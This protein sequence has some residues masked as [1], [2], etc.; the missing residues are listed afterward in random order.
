MRDNRTMSAFM[1][2]NKSA[3]GEV[4]LLTGGFSAEYGDARSGIIN[5]HVS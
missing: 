1:G 4:Q 3:I 5:T 2:I